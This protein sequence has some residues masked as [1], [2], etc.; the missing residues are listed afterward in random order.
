MD[1][2]ILVIFVAVLGAVFLPELLRQRVLDSPL[3]TVSEF[4]RGM[5]ALQ[6]SIHSSQISGMKE[7]NT[8]EEVEPYVRRNVYQSDYKEDFEE[9]FI[10]YP[11]DRARA[12]MEARRHRIIAILTLLTLGTGISIAAPSLRWMIPVHIVMLVLLCTYLLLAILLP[13]Y[14]R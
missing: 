9:E 13:Y 14:N 8:Q 2:A 11:R 12:Q 6:T 7:F 3:Q 10:P 5:A 4:R 1:I